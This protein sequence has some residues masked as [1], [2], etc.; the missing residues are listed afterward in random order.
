MEK[1][2]WYIPTIPSNL[3]RKYNIVDGHSNL[4]ELVLECSFHVE[5]K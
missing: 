4:S 3:I 5:F 1:L 2:A